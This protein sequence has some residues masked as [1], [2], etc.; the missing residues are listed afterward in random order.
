MIVI[1]T[2]PVCSG[3][4]I[5]TVIDSYPSIE[6]RYCPTCGRT[7]YGESEEVIRVPFTGNVRSFQTIP[8]ACAGYKNHPDNGGSGPVAVLLEILKSHANK[9]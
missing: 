9:R 8:A 6:S 1:E 3:A 2:C 5:K 7:Y 4:L